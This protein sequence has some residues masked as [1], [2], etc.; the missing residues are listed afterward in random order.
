MKTVCFSAALAALLAA[1]AAQAEPVK[2]TDNQL[3]RTAAG[4]WV[5][6]NVQNNIGVT[7]LTG[8]SVAVGVLGGTATASVSISSILGQLNIR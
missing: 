1:G 3:A 6:I 5:N 8:V 4:G 7:P 2:L